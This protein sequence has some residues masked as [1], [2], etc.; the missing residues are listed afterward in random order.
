MLR[1]FGASAIIVAF[2]AT[3][4]AG[5]LGVAE[6]PPIDR[7]G[8]DTG[9]PI[10]VGN[11]QSATRVALFITL[12]ITNGFADATD[13]LV[14]TQGL[15]HEVLDAVETVR[16]VDRPQDGDAVLTVLGR[17]T[18]YVELTAALQG[19]DPNVVVS[20]VMLGADERY[21]EGML[22]VGSCGDAATNATSRSASASCYRKIL[23]G[24]GGRNVRQGVTRG[25]RNPWAPCAN[26]LAKDVRAW[27]TQNASRLFALHG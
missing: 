25:A 6:Q 21:I 12:P 18:G 10:L 7:Q 9:S 23:V 20:T 15:I 1:F 2:I 13:A 22:T 11:P 3:G 24:L 16:L 14:E 17:G 19:I 5:T 8:P 27:V 4:S 26:A